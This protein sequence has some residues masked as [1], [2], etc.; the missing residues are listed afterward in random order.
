MFIIIY[1]ERREVIYF[2]DSD[3]AAESVEE[4]EELEF[5]ETMEYNEYVM[6]L[7]IVTRGIISK[8]RKG[9]VLY[10]DFNM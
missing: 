2:S 1:C 5:M 6:Q 3:D 9:E 10:Y 7:E 4:L 8:T